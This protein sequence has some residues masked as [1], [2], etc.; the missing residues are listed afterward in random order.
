MTGCFH[1]I[2]N[3]RFFFFSFLPRREGVG[4]ILDRGLAEVLIFLVFLIFP[5]VLL[6]RRQV[7][8]GTP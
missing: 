2:F 8:Q 6:A 5:T 3:C 7:C 4:M 1:R